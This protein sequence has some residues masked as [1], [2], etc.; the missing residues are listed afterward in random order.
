MEMTNDEL[1][2]KQSSQCQ[3]QKPQQETARH[4][5][6]WLVASEYSPSQPAPHASQTEDCALTRSVCSVS[7]SCVRNI[8]QSKYK[9]SHEEVL[10]VFS[11][12]IWWINHQWFAVLFLFTFLSTLFASL[13]PT[14]LESHAHQVFSKGLQAFVQNCQYHT[15]HNGS[16]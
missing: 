11:R 14:A 1:E 10:P 8:I 15:E 12:I 16:E 6:S 3:H 7:T 5:K 2:Q 9:P 13:V 4:C